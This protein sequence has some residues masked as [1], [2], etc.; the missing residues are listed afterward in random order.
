MTLPKFKATPSEML[1]LKI[2]AYSTIP[3][4]ENHESEM[5]N[6]KPFKKSVNVS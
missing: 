2:Q 4:R 1:S 3:Y 6:R 5:G